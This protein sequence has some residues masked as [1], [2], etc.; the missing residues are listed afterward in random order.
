MSRLNLRSL[1]LFEKRH[2]ETS[3]QL[4]SFHQS[5]P[6]LRARTI[7]DSSLGC[8]RRKAGGK[9]RPG[10]SDLR[11]PKVLPFGHECP[12]RPGAPGPSFLKSNKFLYKIPHAHTCA[13]SEVGGRGDSRPGVGSEVATPRIGGRRWGSISRTRR[14]WDP[15]LA[16]GRGAG[17]GRAPTRTFHARRQLPAQ[18]GLC[19]GLLSPRTPTPGRSS[20]APR[21]GRGGEAKR[22]APRPHRS[23][24]RRVSAGGCRAPGAALRQPSHRGARGPLSGPGLSWERSGGA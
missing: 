3:S 12:R 17:R 16:A 7:P 20:G 13:R 24:A 8:P 9:L 1:V 6:L 5:T 14:V 15:R 11:P 21:E 18:S 10:S 19:L 2:V 4:G 22:G 23:P